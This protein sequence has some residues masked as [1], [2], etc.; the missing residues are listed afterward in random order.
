MAANCLCD[1]DLTTSLFRSVYSSG[2]S[3]VQ[4]PSHSCLPQA[5]LEWRKHRASS[6]QVYERWCIHQSEFHF[7]CPY[8]YDLAILPSLS[9]LHFFIFCLKKFIL[10][11]T[12]WNMSSCN[13]GRK[14]SRALMFLP[15]MSLKACSKC[16]FNS[17][18]HIFT[19]LIFFSYK[20]K[21]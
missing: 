18:L 11:T 2:L 4:G 10:V 5:S 12:F 9:H 6:C 3:V 20:K 21:R 19:C 13:H 8:Q 15:F 14:K 1:L 16:H 7:D 17:S